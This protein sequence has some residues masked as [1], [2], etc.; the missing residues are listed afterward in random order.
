MVQGCCAPPESHPAA[1]R[2]VALRR[3][4][5]GLVPLPARP[6]LIFTL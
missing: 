6:V 3:S 2:R 1:V 5:A 4:S